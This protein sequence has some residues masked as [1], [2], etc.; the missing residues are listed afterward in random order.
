MK[1]FLFIPIWLL[2]II[3]FN[4]PA[5]ASLSL[6]DKMVIHKKSKK[7]NLYYQDKLMK[8]YKI[9]LGFSPVGHKQQS[10][11]GKTPEGKYYIAA[12]NPNSKYHLSLKISYPNQ[13]D[14]IK[15]LQAGLHPGGDI[16]IHGIGE[17]NGW[18]EQLHAKNNWTLGCIAVTNEEIAEIYRATRVGTIVEILP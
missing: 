3:F 14:K 1:Q 12:K 2:S 5:N 15:A 17:K 9:A 11:D 18:L 7:I 13:Q 10:G 8:V 4:Y 6:I 16:M